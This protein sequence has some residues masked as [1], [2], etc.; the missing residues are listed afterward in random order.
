VLATFGNA[1]AVLVSK[2]LEQKEVLHQRGPAVM[3]FWL[4]ATGIPLVVVSVG[5]LATDYSCIAR[6]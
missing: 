4:S 6:H 3:L 2:L 5:R 1:L